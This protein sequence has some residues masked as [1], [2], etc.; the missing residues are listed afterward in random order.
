MARR[1]LDF[2]NGLLNLVT[3]IAIV[4]IGV[5]SGYALWDNQQIYASVENVQSDLLVYKQQAEEDRKKVGAMF[6]ELKAINPDVHAWLTMDNTKIDY[7][8]LYGE[9][10]YEYLNLDV[11]RNFALAGSIYADT[12][13]NPEFRDAYTLV[14]GHHMS[15]GRM[16]GD[17][18]LYKDKTFFDE[19]RTG[20]LY[21]PDRTYDLRTIACMVV[22]AVD[23]V[24]FVPHRWQEDI[25]GV[26]EYALEA[27]L[28]NDA[29]QIERLL[30]ENEAARSGGIQPQIAALATCSAEYNDAR[31]ILLVEM[32]PVAPDEEEE[33]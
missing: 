25:E 28:H 32:I 4:V 17:L 31:T 5:Y 13:C 16:F 8:V 23:Q 24:I 10:N 26:L 21:L 2:L 27:S 29:E 6:D 9:D 22:T 14:H 3:M 12:R 20:L 15:E 33:E 19:N 1:L 7:P 30:K 11:Y 18:D